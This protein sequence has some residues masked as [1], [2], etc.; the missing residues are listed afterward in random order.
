[1]YPAYVS[2]LLPYQ[3]IHGGQGLQE[4]KVFPAF[5][6]RWQMYVCRLASEVLGVLHATHGAVQFRA[7]VSARYADGTEPVS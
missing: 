4:G 1:M 2:F 3:F 6:H 5:F 7:T